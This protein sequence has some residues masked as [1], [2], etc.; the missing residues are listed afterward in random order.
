MSCSENEAEQIIL[1]KC[2]RIYLHKETLLV[3]QIT[4]V[5][6][7]TFFS[8]Y[9]FQ[10]DLLKK[11]IGGINLL[12]IQTVLC[13]FSVGFFVCLITRNICMKMGF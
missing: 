7:S 9:F 2:M 3:V 6:L 13:S 10:R 11:I 5:L 8:S 12:F 1:G 4:A